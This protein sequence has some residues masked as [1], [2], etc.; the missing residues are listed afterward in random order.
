MQQDALIGIYLANIIKI[1]DVANEINI[2]VD[3]T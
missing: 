1:N 3:C 2:I